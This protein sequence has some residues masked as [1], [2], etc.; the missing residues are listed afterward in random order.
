MK[1][2]NNS[3]RIR[4]E[5]GNDSPNVLNVKL[6]QTFE[7]LNILSLRIGQKN[8]YRIPSSSYGVVCGR[9]LLGGK[10]FGV[11]NA[12]VSIFIPKDDAVFDVKDDILY[13]YSSVDSVNYDGIRYNLLPSYIDNECHQN[14]GTMFEKEYVLDNNDII[15][16]FDTYYT[17][18]TTTNNAGDYFIYGVPVGQHTLHV[19]V[20]LSD[21]GKLSV[22]PHDMIGQGYNIDQFESPNKFKADKNLN[23]L[24]QIKS[25]N[26]ALYVYPFWGDTTEDDTNAMI[27]RADIEIDYKFEPTAVFI[28]SIISDKG[29]NSISHK[30]VPSDLSGKMSELITGEGVI[31]MIRKTFDGKVEQFSVKG[32]RVIDGDGVWCYQIPMN[33]DYVC[34]DEFGNVVPTDNPEKGIPTRARVRFRIALDESPMDDSARKR[35]RFLVPN[36]PRL[37]DDYPEFKRT[38][39][40]DYEFGTFTK[41]ES[42]RDM[43][44]NNVYTVKS[45]I[46]RLQ[47][48]TTTST[49][50]Y[51]G[52]KMTN[53]SG[54]NSPMPYNNLAIRM[55]FVYRF[56]CALMLTFIYFVAAINTV[57]ALIGISFLAIGDVFWN[58]A[59][60]RP[61]SKLKW[62]SDDLAAWE[63]FSFLEPVG[64][65]F[66]KV[67]AGMIISLQDFCDDGNTLTNYMPGPGIV[68][69]FIDTIKGKCS[70]VDCLREKVEGENT[71]KCDIYSSA[72]NETDRL[73][74]CV[75]NALAQDNEVTSFDF[76]NDW[77]NG[78]LY[79]PL[80]YRKIKPKRRVFFGLIKVGSV[81]DWCDGNSDRMSGRDNS[82]SRGLKLYHT[83][84]QQREFDDNKKAI[85]RIKYDPD[86]NKETTCYG[87]KC[88]KRA[89]S[90]IQVD[91][92]IIIRKET[93]YG[94]YVYYY[95]SVEYSEYN[96]RNVLDGST[97]D[98]KILFAT[99]LVLLGSLNDCDENGVP[100]FFKHLTETTYQMPPDLL[101]VSWQ[102][103]E[104]NVG[105]LAN[106]EMDD[107]KNGTNAHTE[108]TGADWGNAGFDQWYKKDRFSNDYIKDGEKDHD[109][110]G[111]FYG[112]NCNASFVKP[113]S[114]VN[115]SRVC[116][117]G[118]S[119]DQSI[120]FVDAS[121]QETIMAPDGYISYDEIYNQDARAMFTTMNGN[122]LREK[123]DNKTGFPVYDFNFLYP[124]NFDG[125]LYNLMN[126][127]N[128]HDNNHDGYPDGG[129]YSITYRNNYKI[130]MNSDAYLRFRYGFDPERFGVAF[131]DNT[132]K[133]GW[134]SDNNLNALNQ[135]RFPR[136][137]NSLYFYFGLK[138]GKTAID[139][140]RRNYYSE[141]RN[142]EEAQSSLLLEYQTNSWCNDDKATLRDGYIKFDISNLDMPCTL[143]F[144]NRNGGDDFTYVNINNRKFYIGLDRQELN[145]DGY[146]R[147]YDKER[148]EYAEPLSN[149]LYVITIL[150]V[151]GQ[152][153]KQNISFE[154]E[155]LKYDTYSTAFTLSNDE[156]SVKFPP[157]GS[158]TTNEQVAQ[159]TT[160]DPEN[161]N[162]IRD[163]G[164]YITISGI[165]YDSKPLTDNF[166]IV[167]KP[168]DETMEGYVGSEYSVINGIP[169]ITGVA[170]LS[171]SDGEYV[172]PVP[173]GSQYYV[174][175][176]SEYCPLFGRRSRNSI[177]RRVY[178]NEPLAFKMFING[179]DT[180]LL[181][182]F[183]IGYEKDGNG[184]ISAPYSG[185]DE[186]VGIQENKVKGWLKIYDIGVNGFVDDTE[187][188][189][190]GIVEN[191]INAL[192]PNQTTIYNFTDE[193]IFKESE[194][195]KT[196]NIYAAIP[197]VPGMNETPKYIRVKRNG[198]SGYGYG[199]GEENYDPF[200]EV[201]WIYELAPNNTYQLKYDGSEPAIDI[202]LREYFEM[203][204][205]DGENKRGIINFL[206]RIIQKR[207]DLVDSMIDAFWMYD[208]ELENKMVSVTFQTNET[209]VK[210][211][212]YYI[213]DGNTEISDGDGTY[214]TI[215]D[216]NKDENTITSLSIPTITRN[217]DYTKPIFGK[218]E[219]ANGQINKLPPHC[220]IKNKMESTIPSG[221]TKA[222]FEN[223]I[224]IVSAM[225]A[226]DGGMS[227]MFG[228]HVID[229][230]PFTKDNIWVPLNEHPIY[231]PDVEND[232][233]IDTD[234]PSVVEKF[235]E[236]G[237]FSMNG[238]LSGYFYNG[239][240][241]SQDQDASF[242]TQKATSDIGIYTVTTR[243]VDGVSVPDEFAIPT[244]R[245]MYRPVPGDG[246][247]ATYNDF[248]KEEY[249]YDGFDGDSKE[250]G[251]TDSS[252]RYISYDE[253]TN[254]LTVADERA[255]F[256]ENL[257]P[258]AN[259]GIPE[260]TLVEKGGFIKPKFSEIDD[261]VKYTVFDS[262]YPVY[263]KVYNNDPILPSDTDS[264]NMVFNA[265]LTLNNNAI[266]SG[267]DVKRV[268]YIGTTS[269]GKYR[270]I[271]PVYEV[272][273]LVIEY[274]EN[275]N[276]PVITVTHNNDT[277]Y[278]LSH[279]PYQI[280]VA[281]ETT[282]S[283]GVV[284]GHENISR[285]IPQGSTDS[286]TFTDVD[287][288]SAANIKVYIKDITGIR[289]KTNHS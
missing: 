94:E 22:R 185:Y 35:A 131:Y 205:T 30:C 44:W 161:V 253:N 144:D 179:V 191:T 173:M 199:P 50:K 198:I 120:S 195:E 184:V 233:E 62:L 33:L 97:G 245:I 100:Q 54:D 193:Y 261:D 226:L 86:D 69:K 32:N 128:I 212:I 190:T 258:N 103:N 149:G 271:S 81:D 174:V 139:K 289:R 220:G 46:P 167:I 237:K 204:V 135:R 270:G 231:W 250:T 164:G 150:D 287:T 41:E 180:D 201:T 85:K 229:K 248:Y 244:K 60:T 17:Y 96:F 79:A 210:T 194:V 52:I 49:K 240:S 239:F 92:G 47:K 119:L 172:F 187:T 221:L 27:T 266:P 84:A 38:H 284:E 214:Y 3:Y 168:H 169:T 285:Y 278:Y 99:D 57:L 126:E 64:C 55:G 232:D 90:A 269:D 112:I 178:V 29:S 142:D 197:L 14:V 45:Y 28:G 235:V 228:F 224:G 213:P 148:E 25:Q 177:I 158:I 152:E 252:Y 116:E 208:V 82:F 43:F 143:S 136:Y 87:Y 11:Q 202:S 182:R 273:E 73:I 65:W 257:H 12:K 249:P 209:P 203:D 254:Y 34:M 72:E 192:T 129:K 230:R 70:E 241:T 56:L 115:L 189:Y 242:I 260:D 272:S 211:L 124:E 243:L 181:K 77:I 74:N 23:I 7:F 1:N 277:A 130:E 238:C 68:K 215:L 83:C 274:A 36:N 288:S 132:V 67:A 93:K 107:S 236:G 59:N 262:I 166:V 251:L 71:S 196:L 146:V 61:L 121:Q 125:T 127:V 171:T 114:C 26:K 13:T 118:V 159:D 78:V 51:T 279:Y 104:Q 255:T 282:N 263:R 95:K 88:H 19:D 283:D 280:V 18:T 265:Q 223:N 58:I 113:K 102:V 259:F 4:T 176:V 122:R 175:T 156:L 31:E 222:P 89:L 219:T 39:E 163:I 24:P 264:L 138:T 286:Y 106:D 5:V 186:N 153:Y 227:N 246:Y 66:Y 147:L 110:G 101:S 200:D 137:E 165:V 15:R 155:K 275:N 63:P 268:Y 151:N 206:N 10:S 75:Q 117:F 247:L 170:P 134:F 218:I 2:E 76:Q 111:L 105:A 40:P 234:T 133:L 21:I 154:P 162:Y 8:L 216:N 6:N 42:Y 217:G 188:S 37:T 256:R 281:Y 108:Y 98:V 145:D 48:R 141:C 160:H 140:F 267:D 123:Q 16:I 20:D 157:S 225:S 276:H 207:M 9:V 183:T 109:N 80:W 53:H 91:K